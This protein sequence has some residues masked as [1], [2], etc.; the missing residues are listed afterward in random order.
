[1]LGAG[2]PTFANGLTERTAHRP[3]VIIGDGAVADLFR[4]GGGGEVST[5]TSAHSDPSPAPFELDKR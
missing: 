4:Q 3:S 2:F 1:V 5:H